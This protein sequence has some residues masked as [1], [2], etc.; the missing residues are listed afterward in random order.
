MI[1][2]CTINDVAIS[3]NVSP[4]TMLVDFLRN[5]LGLAGTK[6]GCGIGE[7]GACTV[8][9]DG[10]AMNSCI[11]PALQMEGSA[12]YTVESLEKDGV[13]DP[14]QRAFIENHAVQCGFCTAGMLMSAKALLMRVPH[15]TD[16]EILDA[17]SGNLCRC[18]GYQNIR[19]AVK[20][21]S[22]DGWQ[23]EL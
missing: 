4:N 23:K 22:E 2:N 19:K 12:I 8:I 16:E 21:A 7:C 20:A 11:I 6:K 14:L 18:T 13:L 17:M 3:R 1:L 5:D 10:S 15:P 9:V